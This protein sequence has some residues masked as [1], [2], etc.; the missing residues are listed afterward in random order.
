MDRL[1][2]W[3]R[4]G[5]WALP[6][7]AALTLGATVT[8][9]PDPATRFESW[10]RYVTTDIFLIS[11][12]FGSILGTAF[13]ILGMA[14]LAAFLAGTRRSGL[15][16]WGLVAGIF[17]KVLLTAVFGI[18]AGAQPAIGRAFLAGEQGIQQLYQ[19]V[20][21]APVFGMAGAGV[22]LLSAAFVLLGWA[23]VASELLPRWSGVALALGGPLIGIAGL[24]FGPSQTLGAL[25]ILGAGMGIAPGVHRT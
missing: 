2:G 18:A 13:G 22:L 19:E 5:I 10:S 20:Y 7:Y 15:A 24:I 17:G 8:H 11:Q 1:T 9:Q 16:A 3:I 14:A 6:V 21:S 4:A 23:T 25:L 12:I